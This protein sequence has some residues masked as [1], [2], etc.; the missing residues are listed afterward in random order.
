MA[1][2]HADRSDR[3][4]TYRDQLRLVWLV[5]A[6]SGAAAAFAPASPTGLTVADVAWKTL[7]AASLVVMA[8]FADR[9]SWVVA[10]ALAAAFAVSGPVAVVMVAFVA[11][12]VALVG[13][14]RPRREPLVGA[15]SVGIAAQ[16]L[17]RLPDLLST[18]G[19]TAVVAG[20]AWAVVAGSAWRRVGTPTR[21]RVR[22]VAVWALGITALALVPVAIG[23]VITL[24]ESGKAVRESQAWLDAAQ[25]ADQPAVITHLDAAHDSFDAVDSATGAW[26]TWPARVVPVV[27]QQLD[28]VNLVASSGR[29]ITAAASSAAKVATVEDL[30]VD[31]GR[32][33]LATLEAL[34]A[35]LRDTANQLAT[36][37]ARLDAEDQTWLLPT[38][39]SR[40]DDFH[41]QVAGAA[42]ETTLASDA[43]DV[44][45]ALLGAD[46]PRSYVVLFA[47]PAETREV[48]GFVGNIGLLDADGGTLQLDEVYRSRE[49][50]AKTEHL[51]DERLDELRQAGFTERFMRFEPW[52]HWQNV[53]GTPD[54][55]T[56]GRMVQALA[57]DAFG[58]PIDGVIYVDPEGLAALLR[59]TGP[60]EIDG[61]DVPI[62][63]D[64]AA[65]FLLRDQYEQFPVVD[66]RA[67]FLE[68]VSRTTFERLTRMRLPGPRFI[69]ESLGPAVA[70]GHLRVW[71]VD[72]DEQAFFDQLDAGRDVAPVAAG[73]D[74]MVTVSNA[75]PNKLDAYLHRRVSYDVT[76]DDATGVAEGTVTVDLR[77]DT[78]SL[79]FTDYVV[80]NANGDPR[81]SN[82][83]YLSLYSGLDVRGATLDGR[84]LPL[85]LHDEYG[86]RRA[87]AFVTVPTDGQ[88]QVVFRIRGQVLVDDTFHVRVLTPAL[89]NPDEVAVTVRSTDGEV[90]TPQAVAPDDASPQLVPGGASLAFL[91]QLDLD[92]PL[93]H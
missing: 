26:W 45:P 44:A 71:T 61:L 51:S 86:L 83:T 8:A 24:R 43:L 50:N 58:R 63:A 16:A 4:S 41:E 34:R 69:G 37:L 74:V 21:R 89:A 85:E 76:Y 54:F 80:A 14:A 93:P 47:S 12:G 73:D 72:T 18:T 9:W 42:D 23:A 2:P 77:N 48:G 22:R 70:G 52:V 88:V 30:R 56:T 65:D 53:T 66:E 29:D 19:A 25:D 75:N 15:I 33:D 81:G 20:V 13:V 55:P 60:V 35:P 7:F 91:G 57:P 84:P 64:N 78:P 67:D 1:D 90:A 28:S 3:R 46:G 6:L 32:I 31:E 82:R 40:V 68:R 87:G 5:A 59:I 11:L 92:F 62:G 49:L 38:V 79:D 39:R 17:L 10:A 36:A 27:G